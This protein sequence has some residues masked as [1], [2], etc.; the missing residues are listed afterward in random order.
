MCKCT[1]KHSN[2][3]L[4]FYYWSESSYN[5]RISYSGFNIIIIF[6][7]K[8]FSILLYLLSTLL[9]P[10]VIRLTIRHTIKNHVCDDPFVIRLTIRH[11]IK[12]HVCNDI[13]FCIQHRLQMSFCTCVAFQHTAI[14]LIATIYKMTFLHETLQHPPYNDFYKTI[15]L[16]ILDKKY[17]FSIL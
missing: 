2:Y 5:R 13:F 8:F 11:T 14:D 1:H 3:T 6:L 12:N 7:E 16:Y 15:L 10:F 9:N 4:I 17:I